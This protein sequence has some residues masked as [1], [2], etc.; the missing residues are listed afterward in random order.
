[1]ENSFI[2]LLPSREDAARLHQTFD[3]VFGLQVFPHIKLPLH[4]T[5]YFFPVLTLDKNTDVH[6]L[7]RDISRKCEG[8]IA[9]N[10]EGIRSFQKDGGEFVYYLPVSSDQIISL[11][12][13]LYERFQHIHT[14][15]FEFVPHLSLFY[16]DRN[17][18]AQEKQSIQKLYEGI[19]SVTFDRIAFAA[20]KGNGTNYITV[21]SL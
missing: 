2:C 6:D 1:M 13:S 15:P 5:L 3:T 14:D 10:T 16:P 4:V 20:E 9:A 8:P 21:Q 18:N 17:L 12:D 11:H 7:V 19:G